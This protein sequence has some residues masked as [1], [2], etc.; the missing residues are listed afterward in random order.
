MDNNNPKRKFDKTE[1]LYN[2]VSKMERIEIS[3]SEAGEIATKIRDW[4]IQENYFDHRVE[5]TSHHVAFKCKFTIDSKTE[6]PFYVHLPV[7]KDVIAIWTEFGFNKPEE[8]HFHNLIDEDQNLMWNLRMSL[9]YIGCGFK[10]KDK[11]D[12][13]N[14]DYTT[15][16][17]FDSAIFYD[18]ASKQTLIEEVRRIQRAVITLIRILQKHNIHI[19]SKDLRKPY[20]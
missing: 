9:L 19:H 3:N 7:D 1:Y 12:N 13:E 10:F 8:K 4:L 20:G 17:Y 16:I 2:K 18:G 5:Q 11:E 6:F 15:S 14:T